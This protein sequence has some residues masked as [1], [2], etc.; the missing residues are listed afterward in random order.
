MNPQIIS[1]DYELAIINAFKNGFSEA[2]ILGCFFHLAKNKK[3][4]VELDAAIDIL[5]AELLLYLQSVVQ[6]FEDIIEDDR[7]VE[8]KII[9]RKCGG[10]MITLQLTPIE[11]II[12]QRKSIVNY[13]H[14]DA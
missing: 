4:I 7:I 6:W 3:L 2:E 11:Q 5:G 14:K 12:T 9:C 10:F 8:E 13:T 1:C